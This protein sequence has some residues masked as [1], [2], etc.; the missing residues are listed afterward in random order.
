MYVRVPENRLSLMV[1]KS[2]FVNGKSIPP[3]VIVPGKNIIVS[4]FYKNI[5]SEKIVTVSS[6]GYT[7][8]EICLT[9]L[10]YFIKHN[11]YRPD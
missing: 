9:W 5:T 4:W 6:L 8:K 10:D 1:I 11:N 3:L 7:N 2:I